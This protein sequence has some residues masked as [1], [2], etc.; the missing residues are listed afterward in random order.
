[1]KFFLVLLMSFCTLLVSAQTGSTPRWLSTPS[2]SPDGKWIAFEYKGDIFKVPSAGGTAMAITITT[3][4]ESNPVWSHDGKSIAFA[5][6]RYGNFDVYVMPSDGGTATR[7]TW[8][9]APDIPYDFSPDD[10]SVIFGTSRNDIYT[11]VR[12]PLPG[13]FRKLYTVP[14]KG[15]RSV[16]I[17]SAGMECA[18][19]NKEGSTIL[20]QDRKGFESDERKHERASVTRDI[21]TYDIHSGKYSKLTDFQGN[22]LEPVWGEGNDYYYLSERNDNDLNVYQSSINDTS[23]QTQLTHFKRNPVRGLSRSGNGIL[24]FTNAG[25]VYT[26]VPGNEPQKVNIIL[27]ADFAQQASQTLSVTNKDISEMALSPDGMEVAFVYRGDIFVASADG[28]TTKR[29]TNTPY[30]ERMIQFSPDGRSILY[31]V[32]ND[33]SW[34]INQLHIA[35]NEELY[36]YAATVIDDKPVIATDKDEFQGLYS[37]DGKKIAYLEERNILK[38][39]D[40]ETKKNG[41][42]NTTGCQFFLCRWR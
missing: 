35:N 42:G 22:D 39:Y 33:N 8:N 15:G 12:F 21:W 20:F 17:N 4:Y 24:C 31:S 10:K 18:T 29:L 40:T 25:D 3:D 9:S 32:E 26:L 16:M 6:D 1:M 14:V 19:Y 37:P 11:S 38:V 36:F 28:N 23:Q 7:L 13:I 27:R 41:Y 5:S 30:Q 2:I 34:N